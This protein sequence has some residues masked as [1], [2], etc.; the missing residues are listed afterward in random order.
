[1]V[2][3]HKAKYIGVTLLTLTPDLFY[4]LQKKLKG[5]PDT[6]RHGVL[7]YK[8]IV[9]SPAH[10]YVSKIKSPYSNQSNNQK[11]TFQGRFTTG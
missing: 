8:V 7:I 5:I 2:E 1:M 9:G 10:L 6:I 4:E 3:E 11:Y